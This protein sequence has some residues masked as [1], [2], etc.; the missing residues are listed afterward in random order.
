[1][2]L[3]KHVVM[4]EEGKRELKLSLFHF[5]KTHYPEDAPKMKLLLL[6]FGMFREYAQ[7]IQ[8]KV[9]PFFLFPSFFLSL[10]LFSF[11]FLS[12]FSPSVLTFC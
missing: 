10:F 12:Y 2:M 4:N 6:R 3:A 1:M 5:L 7:L 8:D 11:L 9:C